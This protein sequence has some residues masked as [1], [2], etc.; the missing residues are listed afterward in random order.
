MAQVIC[1][2][3][4]GLRKAE[5]TVMVEDVYGAHHFL[6]VDRHLLSQEGNTS[7]LPVGIIYI[8]E[9][10]GIALV[11]LPLEADSGVSRLW[12]YLDNLSQDSEIAS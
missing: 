8:D 2:V 10:K 9:N 1:E 11:E 4:E 12:V 6:P 5:A 7:Y 3:S